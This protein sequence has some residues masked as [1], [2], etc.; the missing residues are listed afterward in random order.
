[1]RFD[2]PERFLCEIACSICQTFAAS[3]LQSLGGTCSRIGRAARRATSEVLLS[4]ARC[5]INVSS[6][7][8]S[9]PNKPES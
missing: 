3:Q 8:A 2:S 6:G 1:M 4:A 7:M 9:L 5:G